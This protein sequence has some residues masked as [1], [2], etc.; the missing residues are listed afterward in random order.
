MVRDR[1][2]LTDKER[3]RIKGLREAGVTLRE[4][5]SSRTLAGEASF[6]KI[7][8]ELGLTCSARTV[9]R[10]LDRCD[11]LEYSKTEQTL[12][13]TPVH[14][15]ARL[16]W[17]TE[18]LTDDFDWSCVIF[19]DEKRFNLDGPDGMKHYWRDLR[20]PVA[21]EPTGGRLIT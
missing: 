1:P 19:S 20:R 15:A 17:A 9:R 11:F 13:L 2:P 21:D 8:S 14:K 10:L 3:G 16:S 18:K 7:K 4:I 12:D 6:T 5:A